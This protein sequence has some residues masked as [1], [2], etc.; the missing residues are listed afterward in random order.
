MK[1]LILLIAYLFT[2]NLIRAQ[3]VGA[4]ISSGQTVR[5]LEVY[6]WMPRPEEDETDFQKKFIL[7]EWTP[8]VVKFR[9]GRPD[10]HVPLIFDLHNNTPYF[11]QDSLIMEFTDSVS[12]IIMKP[13]IKED[14]LHIVFRRFYPPIQANTGATFYQVLVDGKIQLLKCKAKTILL[15]KYPGLLEEKKKVPEQLYFAYLPDGR[16]IQI[17]TGVSALTEAMPEFSSQMKHIVEK[18]K[19][20]PRDEERLIRFFIQ[21]NNLLLQ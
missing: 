4:D 17:D 15:F 12:Q 5:R 16:M 10:M 2:A 9:S 18:L 21:L 14:T 20:K 19:I 8:A 13:V 11:L 6:S 3:L 1:S 7:Q